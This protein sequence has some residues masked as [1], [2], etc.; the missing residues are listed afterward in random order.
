M[1]CISAAYAVMLCPSV[2]LCVRLSVTFVHSVKT[3][4]DI[5]EI[6]S[7]S[8]SHTILDFPYQTAQQFSDG[9]PPKGGVECR[10]GRQ[11]IA[12]LSLYLAAVKAITGRCCQQG[13]R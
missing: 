2:S 7:P 4:K 1:L 6:F 12:I 3:N 8:G 5:F 10:W 11:K 13:R 9:N